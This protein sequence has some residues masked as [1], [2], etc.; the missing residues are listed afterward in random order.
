MTCCGFSSSSTSPGLVPALSPISSLHMPPVCR[1]YKNL[2]KDHA[3]LLP[4][5][6][7]ARHN[8]FTP[9]LQ[10]GCLA[11]PWSALSLMMAFLK[12]GGGETSSCGEDG[13]TA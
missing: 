12:Q 1:L 10:Y 11:V 6:E 8:P 7:A 5:A 2:A 3:W 9:P 13:R 4:F